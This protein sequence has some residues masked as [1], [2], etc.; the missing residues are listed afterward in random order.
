MLTKFQFQ[1]FSKNLLPDICLAQILAR[2]IPFI[3]KLLSP[4]FGNANG[5][6]VVFF[7]ALPKVFKNIEKE[8]SPARAAVEGVLSAPKI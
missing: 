8:I 3:G 5:M 7:P 1:H 4:L 2:I 6:S